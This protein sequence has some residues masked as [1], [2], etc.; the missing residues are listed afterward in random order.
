MEEEEEEFEEIS[1]LADG[2]DKAVF[3]ICELL[4][5][6]FA[7][8][9][10]ETL[11]RGEHVA[12]YQ[13]V[14][15]AVGLFFAGLGPAWSTV[16]RHFP[17]NRLL[18]TLST[19][20]SDARIWIVALIAGLLITAAPGLF[21]RATHNETATLSIQSGTREHGDASQAEEMERQ[22][23]DAHRQMDNMQ[24]VERSLRKRLVDAGLGLLSPLFGSTTP[25]VISLSRR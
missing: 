14:Y 1:D 23:A 18:A 4:G 5:L 17:H 8:P 11:F 6:L 22:L 20:A 15:G 19:A 9:L 12:A 25:S 7:L 3:G 21:R 24:F 13:W 16:R 10:G 2:I